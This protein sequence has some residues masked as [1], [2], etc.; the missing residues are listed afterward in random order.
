MNEA[1]FP[2]FVIFCVGAMIVSLV[3]IV[4]GWIK[5]FLDRRK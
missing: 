2:A 3:E 5:D 4:W 1:M